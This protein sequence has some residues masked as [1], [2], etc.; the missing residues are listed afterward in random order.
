M[1]AMEIDEAPDGQQDHFT[2]E[3]ARRHQLG[4]LP[5][6]IGQGGKVGITGRLSCP[7]PQ[8][9]RLRNTRQRRFPV[10]ICSALNASKCSPR[11]TLVFF[12][13]AHVSPSTIPTYT[14]FWYGT[15][16]CV[17]AEPEAG[18]HAAGCAQPPSRARLSACRGRGYGSSAPSGTARGG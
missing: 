14:T 6:E 16:A 12:G 1:F 17:S 13:M 10:L 5:R 9:I 18:K 8:S 7:V 4:R 3:R 2:P 15:M 11:V